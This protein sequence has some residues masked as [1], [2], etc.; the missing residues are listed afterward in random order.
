[1]PSLSFILVT[2]STR[3]FASNLTN[4]MIRATWRRHDRLSG[5]CTHPNTVPGLWS[6]D[7]DDI[8]LTFVKQFLGD[9]DRDI[10]H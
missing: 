2:R 6:F 9:L 5:I 4:I 8:G 7:N 1:M 10:C 3:L